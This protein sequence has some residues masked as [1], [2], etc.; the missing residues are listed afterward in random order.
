M[1]HVG[2]LRAYHGWL[3]VWAE[4]KEVVVASHGEAVLEA[5]H[6]R[7]VSRVLLEDVSPGAGVLMREN[8]D[9][10]LE[11]VVDVLNFTPGRT[12]GGVTVRPSAAAGTLVALAVEASHGLIPTTSRL[13][14]GHVLLAPGPSSASRQPKD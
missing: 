12:T 13:G 8:A 11:D 2:E 6:D 5:L 1:I 7:G 4:H 9:W 3:D 10:F 14:S